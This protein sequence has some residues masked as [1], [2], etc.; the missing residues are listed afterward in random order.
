MVYVCM[1]I[2]DGCVKICF[3]CVVTHILEMEAACLSIVWP[4]SIFLWPLLEKTGKLVPCLNLVSAIV[5]LSSQSPTRNYTCIFRRLRR[6]FPIVEDAF[7]E[8]YWSLAMYVGQRAIKGV[9]DSIWGC[10]K[11]RPPWNIFFPGGKY[12][13]SIFFVAEGK[14]RSPFIGSAWQLKNAVF[15]PN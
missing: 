7:V 2:R 3:V 5:H 14:L 9:F 12:V 6:Q 15:W 4:R 13:E 8:K 10:D 11:T 1:C